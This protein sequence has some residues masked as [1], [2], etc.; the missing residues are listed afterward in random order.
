MKN[1]ILIF[2]PGGGFVGCHARRMR[3]QQGCRF[4]ELKEDASAKSGVSEEQAPQDEGAEAEAENLA[5]DVIAVVNGE[6]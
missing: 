4:G 1:K 6:N 2:L 5:D 3:R